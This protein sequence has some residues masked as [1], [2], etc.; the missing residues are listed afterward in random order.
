MKAKLTFDLP[1]EQE[2]FDVAV[3]GSKIAG[4]VFDYDQALRHILKYE[5]HP[6]D[7]QDAIEKA[8]ELLREKCEEWQVIHLINF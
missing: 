8:R 5:E 4:A 7:Y 2:D 6:G 3:G 1:E